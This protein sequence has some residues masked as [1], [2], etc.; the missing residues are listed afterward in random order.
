[1]KEGYRGFRESHFPSKCTLEVAWGRFFDRPKKGSPQETPGVRARRPAT[2]CRSQAAR[3]SS[4]RPGEESQ[5]RGTAVPLPWSLKGGFQRGK[6]S[7]LSPFGPSFP[8]LSLRRKRCPRRDSGK[9][10]P[11]RQGTAAKVAPP[12]LLKRVKISDK[13]FLEKETERRYSH[14]RRHP[15]DASIS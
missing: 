14:G 2:K 13:I 5:G 6:E 9:E 1:M 15:H 7:K 3:P 8:P 4:E 11:T 10:R 12:K